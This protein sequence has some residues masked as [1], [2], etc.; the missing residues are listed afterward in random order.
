MQSE[1]RRMRLKPL[2]MRANNHLW[3]V[4]CYAAAFALPLLWQY[5]ALRLIYPYKLYAT[6]PDAAAHVLSAFPALGKWLAPV[7]A[8]TAENTDT[9]LSV[10]AAREQV[11]LNALT[12]VIQ[13]GWR[14]THRSPVFSARAT[15]RAIRDY[16]VTML[17]IWLVNAAAAAGVWIFGVQFIQG[18]T[19][20]DYAVSFGVFL[21]LPLCAA[22]VSRYA[23]SPVI[24]GKHAFFKRI[25]L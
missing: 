13:L 25:T 15:L 16:R 2:R 14:F 22:F 11:W 24:S 12:L 3:C 19:L 17:L 8:R 18:R 9:L 7:A 1:P 10:L 21:L 20:W 23:A 5:A 6:A 4:F